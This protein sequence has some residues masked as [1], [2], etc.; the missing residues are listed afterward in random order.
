MECAESKGGFKISSAFVLQLIVSLMFCLAEWTMKIPLDELTRSKPSSLHSVLSA[1][2]SIIKGVKCEKTLES[3]AAL[4]DRIFPTQKIPGGKSGADSPAEGQR[5]LH[6][7]LTTSFSDPQHQ[8][9]KHASEQK[10]TLAIK[11]ASKAVRTN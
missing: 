4:L 7:P 3:T 6:P 5:S 11:L 8:E 10:A 2:D 9:D 1:L